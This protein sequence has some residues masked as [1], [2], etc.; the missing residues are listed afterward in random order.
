MREAEG[1]ATAR[2]LRVQVCSIGRPTLTK[3]K[4]PRS[5]HDVRSRIIVH[6]IIQKYPTEITP[7]AEEEIKND[8]DNDN[9]NIEIKR[10]ASVRII[11]LAKYFEDKILKREEIEY[12]INRK[13]DT[14]NIILDKPCFKQVRKF[15]RNNIKLNL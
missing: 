5:I 2:C 14:L 6:P 4:Q 11:Y 3:Q 13:D 9:Q 12:N 15:S 10:R 1:L 7:S 8:N